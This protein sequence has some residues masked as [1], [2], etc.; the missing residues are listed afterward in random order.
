MLE[1]LPTGTVLR[2]RYAVLSV[3][4][5]GGMGRTYLAQDRER[6]SEHCVVK[7]FTL[8]GASLEILE[9]AK[10][11]FQ[12][13]ANV[14]Y[15]LRHPQIPQFRG[16]FES[17]GR[18]FLV[19][20]YVEGKTYRALLMERLGMGQMFTEAEIVTLLEQILPVLSYIHQRDIIHR[21][22]SPENLMERS[23][24]RVPVLIDFG[25]VQAAQGQMTSELGVPAST[26]AGKM[27]FAPPEQLQSGSAYASSDL[28]ALAA[29][30]LVLLTGKEPTDLF[31]SVNLTW[32]WQ[33]FVSVGA[34]LARV[35]D[36]M[37]SYRPA[38]R[39]RNAEEVIQALL[40]VQASQSQVKTFAVGGQGALQQTLAAL[41][42]AAP[43][44]SSDRSVN[45]TPKSGPTTANG[46]GIPWYLGVLLV[47]VAGIGSW[48]VTSVIYDRGRSVPPPVVES[49]ATAEPSPEPTPTPQPTTINQSL[50]FSP[51]GEGLLVANRTGSLENG[52]TLRFRLEAEA[53]QVL[54]VSVTG[55]GTMQ[56]S[57]RDGDQKPLDDRA[58][59][60]EVGYWRGI[61]PTSGVYFVTIRTAPNVTAAEYKLEVTLTNPKPT[62]TP[63][64]APTTEP[65]PEPTA[66]PDRQV[67]TRT[68][69]SP[70]V[71]DVL[72]PT[73]DV[74]YRVEMLEG[75][76]LGVEVEGGVRVEV[77]APNG[78][79]VWNTSGGN[80]QVISGTSVGT[81]EIR[82]TGDR[83]EDIPYRLTVTRE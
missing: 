70:V 66:P 18:M 69:T 46:G 49:T 74:R 15:Q 78:G 51:R 50:T 64:P 82:I 45:P 24:D 23:P 9:K 61:L 40:M 41:P 76:L 75:Q 79:L 14:L 31:D 58:T 67:E 60:N 27:G 28:Y 62:P 12:R 65:P 47:V 8:M 19:Q 5:Q 1:P 56:L 26:V 38:Q 63:E 22:I 35:L 57:V 55:I 32:R 36:K 11:L 21:D 48:G 83:P 30:V 29:T 10:E 43:A 54:T 6:F 80:R 71:E 25:V 42:Q 7:E 33:E 44:I 34:P 53:N 81:Y 68:L 59:N 77:Y 3:L 13:E 16:V 4:G 20:D 39:Y 52:Q 73:Q 37:L 17:D 72:T 2:D